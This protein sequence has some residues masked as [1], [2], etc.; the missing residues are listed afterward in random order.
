VQG[1]VAA[2]ADLDKLRRNGHTPISYLA[3][4]QQANGAV[5]YS[6]TSAQTPVWVTGQALTA[7]SRKPFPVAPPKRKHVHVAAA[8]APKPASAPKTTTTKAKVPVAHIAAKT[9]APKSHGQTIAPAT[10]VPTATIAT[11]TTAVKPASQQVQP[12]TA[13]EKKSSHRKAL[14]IALAIVAAVA[15]GAGTYLTRKRL[16][17]RSSPA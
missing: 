6:R 4:L 1:L 16:R 10:T 17:G 12:S 5:R 2:G 8:S 3:S 7:F 11:P 14:V 9:K 15:L 13:H